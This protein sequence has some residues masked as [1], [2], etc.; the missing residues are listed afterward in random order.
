MTVAFF[1][2][3]IVTYDFFHGNGPWNYTYE[4]APCNVKKLH[5]VGF[6][7]DEDQEN[8]RIASDWYTAKDGSIIPVHPKTISKKNG[9]TLTFI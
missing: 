5:I 7:I 9:S 2:P 3:C 4:T 1:K 6:F 8:F